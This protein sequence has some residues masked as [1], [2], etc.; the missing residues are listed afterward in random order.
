MD[1]IEVTRS[2]WGLT[3]EQEALIKLCDDFATT[4]IRPRGHE[5][6]EADNGSAAVRQTFL[7]NA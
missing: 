3:N 5:V 4:E 6:D 1:L 7:P 2:V